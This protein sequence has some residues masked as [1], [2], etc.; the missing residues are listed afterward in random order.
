M[1]KD[2]EMLRTEFEALKQ[3]NQ[4]LKRDVENLTRE[5]HQR[6]SKPQIDASMVEILKQQIQVCTED[7]NTERKDREKAVNRAKQ[8]S[9]EVNRLINEVSSLMLIGFKNKLIVDK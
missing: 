6:R 7:F 5:L 1:E 2:S 4:R 3:E 8:L 9:D